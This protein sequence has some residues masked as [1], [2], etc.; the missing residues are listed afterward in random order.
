MES[1]RSGGWGTSRRR[2]HGSG[3]TALV[4][5]VLLLSATAPSPGSP[6]SLCT[7]SLHGGCNFIA[8]PSRKRL[9]R[10][11]DHHRVVVIDGKPLVFGG[12]I[13]TPAAGPVLD[14]VLH[15]DEWVVV[16]GRSALR[17]C[18]RLAGVF[19]GLRIES[20]AMQA[21]VIGIAER[22]LPLTE[23]VPHRRCIG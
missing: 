21:N 16:V 20:E 2:S 18:R 12:E 8:V 23:L 15:G 1:S 11:Y 6:K 14:A 19:A 10:G 22:V 17:R 7:S 3:L 13:R 5:T 9:P 4:V